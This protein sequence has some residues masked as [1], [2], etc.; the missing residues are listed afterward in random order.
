MATYFTIDITDL[1]QT[2]WPR[3]AVM[4]RANWINWPPSRVPTS[5]IGANETSSVRPSRCTGLRALA[6]K[7]AM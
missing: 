4:P 2:A 1:S 5:A 3:A 6:V 7:S